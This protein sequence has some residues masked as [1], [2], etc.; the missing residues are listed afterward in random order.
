MQNW[1]SKGDTLNLT[2]PYAVASGAGAL[3]GRIFGVASDAVAN[4]VIGVFVVKGL[5]DIAKDTSTFTDGSLVYWDN[6]AKLATSV[7]TAHN[8]IGCAAMQHPDGNVAPGGASGDATVR[9]NL[10]GTTLLTGE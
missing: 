7:T 2:A 8:I 3:V 9:V 5:M 6:T 1:I 10:V 4:G